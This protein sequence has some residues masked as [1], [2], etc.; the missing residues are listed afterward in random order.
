VPIAAYS[1]LVAK[2]DSSRLAKLNILGK[3]PIDFAAFIDCQ[4][5]PPAVRARSR[6]P[7]SDPRLET[8]KLRTP[9]DRRDQM[10]AQIARPRR[11]GMEDEEVVISR[12]NP[13]IDAS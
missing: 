5:P 10:R 7:F 3:R 8:P 2:V 4:E 11:F 1:A 12:H 13:D 6:G 9:M